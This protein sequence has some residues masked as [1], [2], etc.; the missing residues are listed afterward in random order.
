MPSTPLV[1]EACARLLADGA[2]YISGVLS[3]FERSQQNGLHSQSVRESEI[4]LRS[5]ADGGLEIVVVAVVTE[6][7]AQEAEALFAGAVTYHADAGFLIEVGRIARKFV[8]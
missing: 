8:R 7:A 1:I 2:Y 6:A 5:F 3:N 4:E